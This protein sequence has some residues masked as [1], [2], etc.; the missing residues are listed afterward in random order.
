M[1]KHSR[2]R[3]RSR[4]KDKYSKQQRSSSY[5][6]HSRRRTPSPHHSRTAKEET[7]LV[8]FTFLDYKNELNRVLLGYS[9]RDQLIDNVNDFWL[10]IN[11]YENLLRKSGQCILPIPSDFSLDSQESNS[12]VPKDYNKVYS[13]NL[14][15]SIAFEQ[16]YSRLPSSYDQPNKITILKVKQ[17]LQIVIHYLDFKQKEKFH[18]LKKL[19]KSQANLPVAQYRNE[20]IEAVRNEQVVILA[21]D[22]GCGKSTQVPQYL[23][24]AGF[25]GVGECRSMRRVVENKNT[26]SNISQIQYVRSREELLVFHCRNVFLMK[27]CANMA[28]KLAIKLD[29]NAVRV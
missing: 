7:N 13:C 5:D 25:D 2:K 17:F 10:F 23:F 4:S 12:L 27:C 3:N 1:G 18:K 22:T 24:Q 26:F 15:L 19:R 8:D 21:G 9:N 29:L 20:I 16:L 14:I 28:P 11:K 6:R